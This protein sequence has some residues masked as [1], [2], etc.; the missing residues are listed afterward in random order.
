[1]NRTDEESTRDLQDNIANIIKKYISEG[2][3]KERINVVILDDSRVIGSYSLDKPR[4]LTI[5]R[6]LIEFIES[7][8]ELA[9]VIRHELGHIESKVQTA[10]DQIANHRRTNKKE[11]FPHDK[12]LERIVEDE[13]DIKTIKPM[14]VN[15]DN[16]YAV[17]DFHNRIAIEYG[18]IIGSSSHAAS[19]HR[20]DLSS[21]AIETLGRIKGYKNEFNIEP[22]QRS[23]KRINKFKT[24]NTNKKK[25]GSRIKKANQYIDQLNDSNFRSI[26][27]D[28]K[29]G[30]D[31][32]EKA[33]VLKR[34][35]LKDFNAELNR[36]NEFLKN[37]LGD[38]YKDDVMIKL[39]GQLNFK[40]DTLCDNA[41][42]QFFNDSW[43]PTSKGQIAHLN[44]MFDRRYLFPSGNILDFGLLAMKAKEDL[45]PLV[46]GKLQDTLQG[47]NPNKD[48]IKLYRKNIE[49]ANQLIE[50]F[51]LALEKWGGINSKNRIMAYLKGNQGIFSRDSEKYVNLNIFPDGYQEILEKNSRIKN[52]VSRK[53]VGLMMSES[54][55]TF[56]EFLHYS[57][58]IAFAEANQ[59]ELKKY[60]EKFLKELKKHTSEFSLLFSDG[61]F[62][63]F[64]NP[65]MMDASDETL[66]NLASYRKLDPKAANKILYDGIDQLFETAI[67]NDME[68]FDAE[69]FLSTNLEFEMKIDFI[70][71]YFKDDFYKHKEVNEI[72]NKHYDTIIRHY[73]SIAENFKDAFTTI[74]SVSNNADKYGGV[75]FS[76]NT[77]NSIN[78]KLVKLFRKEG[79]PLD[80]DESL[81]LLK[82]NSIDLFDMELTADDLKTAK[83]IL[84]FTGLRKT[85]NN[86]FDFSVIYKN[87][88][89]SNMKPK[90]RYAYLLDIINSCNSQFYE[91]NL[92]KTSD[93]KKFL[94]YAFKHHPR[95]FKPFLLAIGDK[96]SEE[97]LTKSLK[98]SFKHKIGFYQSQGK[99]Y[100]EAVELSSQ[101][102]F[103]QLYDYEL[104]WSN[105][106]SMINN[107]VEVITPNNLP[108][109]IKFYNA[110]FEGASKAIY[111]AQNVKL[112]AEKKAVYS[113]K[114]IILLFQDEA[115]LLS[116]PVNDLL[117]FQDNLK[118][119]LTNGDNINDLIAKHFLDNF[120]KF[121]KDEQRRI[122]QLLKNSKFLSNINSSLLKRDIVLWHI[123][124]RFHTE[125]L[126]KSLK[127][128]PS[129]IVEKNEVRQIIPKIKN[130]I[131]NQFPKHSHVIDM[132]L[133]KLQVDL[134]M[135]KEESSLLS[136]LRFTEE[137]LIKSRELLGAD[138]N[139]IITS[140]LNAKQSLE[141]LD[142]ITGKTNKIT[143]TSILN[144]FSEYGLTKL[145]LIRQSYRKEGPVI[146]G[147]LILPLF[148]EN[149][150]V[151]SDD[152]IYQKALEALLGD[153][154]KDK[155]FKILIETYLEELH[156]GARKI[157]LSRLYS[158]S[159]TSGTKGIIN[160]LIQAMDTMGVKGAQL[161]RASGIVP[162]KYRNNISHVFNDALPP[163][164]D[165]IWKDLRKVF[166][167]NFKYVKKLK[168]RIGS[169]SV[170]YTVFLELEDPSDSKKII[171]ISL[172]IQKSN[173]EG[174]VHNENI[175]LTKVVKRLKGDEF[176]SDPSIHKMGV[177]LDQIRDQTHRQLKKGGVELDHSVQRNAYEQIKDVYRG[178]IGGV[179]ARVAKPI[180]LVQDLIA[181]EHAKIASAYEYFDHIPLEELSQKEQQ[182][183]S[184]AITSAENHGQFV[185]GVHD[186]D[187]H[188][189]NWLIIKDNTTPSGY[190]IIRIDY[191]QVEQLLPNEIKKLQSLIS[192]L[193]EPKIN[194]KHIESIRNDFQFIFKG[195]EIP[196]DF[197]LQLAKIV[198]S[199]DFPDF[200]NPMRRLFRIQ[201][202]L[203]EK[204]E[205]A[206]DFILGPKIQ[207][208]I[209]SI[210][211]RQM[212]TE[213]HGGTKLQFDFLKAIG[214]SKL[215][216]LIKNLA[217]YLCI[218]LKLYE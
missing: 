107:F 70:N 102:I 24:E 127:I 9:Y 69:G 77:L 173:V 164:W 161:L 114:K 122:S 179:D 83:K 103:K 112:E 204:Y 52:I 169:G 117:K 29:E 205:N 51:D 23:T 88:L 152:K 190:S 73:T 195:E 62:S 210:S 218:K 101:K 38:Q 133:N 182:L 21:I 39:Q 145:E 86:T 181:P 96:K 178:S 137:K 184:R 176:R 36:H 120:S 87:L 37:L 129:L 196:K 6:G 192:I 32:F 65:T 19:S 175:Q 59:N 49:E 217:H 15:G 66:E 138:V 158:A 61:F 151:L 47:K 110:Y 155:K 40:L 159:N 33:K 146:R 94:E 193:T 124:D 53:G 174:K 56:D 57:K 78:K 135:S 68:I 104:D 136:Y 84:K 167:K 183:I 80:F 79:I 105:R 213:F 211:K 14:L 188:Y 214:K 50:K 147:Y 170:D 97:L 60:F 180:K 1:M 199:K 100:L 10:V 13:V 34:G 131:N 141:V 197:E 16:P 208:Q 154:Y 130:L 11:I 26:F 67:T 63:F 91:L 27:K 216:I 166:G 3:K 90:E 153:Y 4:F 115:D 12:L 150:G 132:V 187:P 31:P 189:R 202:K 108:S 123:N 43:I 126:A 54:L 140:K 44:T 171:D 142:F 7:D 93:Y 116:I 156:V 5:S 125:K 168:G 45:I 74:N 200:K 18:D 48:L 2:E 165:D 75:K 99:S 76:I 46:E 98:E 160:A 198:N 82:L 55:E 206:Q 118:F 209:A 157:F 191:A 185:E 148:D 172:S 30:I 134:L 17:Y 8:D 28:I 186:I 215:D 109:A 119:H 95:N 113:I 149:H 106:N 177:M 41:Y 201:S 85:F 89:S 42:H 64:G 22:K 163:E 58:A 143:N 35:G 92:D 203:M 25:L 162:E 111:S 128:N 71:K 194:K 72:F 20:R 139:T 121:T 144:H 81:T 207:N 212:F